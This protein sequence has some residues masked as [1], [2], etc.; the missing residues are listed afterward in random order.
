MK[1]LDKK[2]FKLPYVDSQTY[3]DLLRLGLRYDKQLR[4]YSAEGLDE[5]MVEA[6]LG[7][8]SRILHEPV[9]FEQPSENSRNNRA[10]QNCLICG[11]GFACDECRYF[12]LCETKNVSSICV[13]GKCLEEGKVF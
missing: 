5:T 12:E 10:D 1:I 9:C 6:V 3:R 8:L 7:L 4:S 13:C 2:G 11:K